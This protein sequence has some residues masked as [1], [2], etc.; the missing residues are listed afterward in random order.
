MQLIN[1][2]LK[3]RFA[4]FLRAEASAS[5]L[6]YPVPPRTVI[7]GIL[8]AILGIPKDETQQVLEPAKIAASGKLPKTHWHRA[9]LRKDPPAPLPRIIKKTDKPDRDTKP[10]KATLI[11][12]EWLFEPLYTVWVSIPEQYHS[13]LELRLRERRWHFTPYLG[14]SEM[15]ADI[16]YL[17]SEEGSPLPKGIYDVISVFPQ[18]LGEIDMK[19]AFQR[20]LAIHLLRMPQSITSDR[21]F[22]H[23]NYLAEREAKAIPVITDQA[24]RVG[25]RIAMFL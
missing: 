12:Q 2:R 8:G 1:F 23:A 17:G 11:L 16:E 19:Q 18:D 20:E 7:L 15:M 10:E 5:A 25:D 22:Y 6:S 13:N 24:Y 14:L 9:K 4:H 3:G 21:V